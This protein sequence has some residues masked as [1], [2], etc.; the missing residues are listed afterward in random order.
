MRAWV[1]LLAVILCA[2]NPAPDRTAGANLS[3]DIDR[4]IRSLEDLKGSW[5]VVSIDGE[6]L[7][8]MAE[9]PSSPSQATRSAVR[10][11]ATRS[12]GWLFFPRAA[13]RRIAGAVTQWGVQ[14]G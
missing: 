11:V 7:P 3:E 6:A 12:A 1:S 5:R 10:S 8:E 9:E 13:L 14:G 4:H 2:C